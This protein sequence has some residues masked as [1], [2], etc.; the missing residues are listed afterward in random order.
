MEDGLALVDVAVDQ[1]GCAE[2]TRPITHYDLRYIAEGVVHY[3]V[4]K[5]PGAVPT[6][7]PTR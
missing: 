5:M 4:P 6:R 7:R 3:Y 1:G 2:T